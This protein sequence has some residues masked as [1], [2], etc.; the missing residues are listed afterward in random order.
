MR[1][2]IALSVLAGALAVTGAASAGGWATVGVSSPPTG[3]GPGETWRPDIT[4]LQH[5]VTPLSGLTPIVTIREQGSGRA[6]EFIALETAEA[7]VY[8]AEVVFPSAG[9]WNVVVESGFG[10]S[11]LTFGPEMIAAGPGGVVPDSLPA[12][13]LAAV[14]LFLALLVAGTLALRRHQRPT[15]VP[16]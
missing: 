7:G 14:G 10:D 1:Y 15:A 4:I 5:G 8:E 16:R 12:L 3:V 6:Q 2:L 11:R 9:E 13:P